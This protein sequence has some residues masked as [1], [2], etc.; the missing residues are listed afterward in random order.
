MG[1]TRVMKHVA[2]KESGQVTEAPVGGCVAS[3][4]AVVAVR[5]LGDRAEGL[6]KRRREHDEADA[7]ERVEAGEEEP[8][9]R[10]YEHVVHAVG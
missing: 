6:A 4:P 1:R 7:P 9:L 2:R 8:A 3:A 10:S 5:Q